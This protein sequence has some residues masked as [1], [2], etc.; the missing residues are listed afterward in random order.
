MKITIIIMTLFVHLNYGVNIKQYR[1]IELDRATTYYC[2]VK[3]CDSDPFTTADGS[4]IDPIKLR[5]KEIRWCALSRDLIYDEYRQ[6]IHTEGFRGLFEFGDTIIVY[7]KTCPQI[8]GK[9][10]IHDTMNKRY[11][12]SID[13]LIHPDNNKPKLGVCDDVKIL[14]QNKDE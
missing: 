12:N 6:G 4:V 7:S 11:K 13:F 8:N 2:E 1:P 10:V 9:W 3:Q 14:N 5:N